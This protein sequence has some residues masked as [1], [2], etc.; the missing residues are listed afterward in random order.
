MKATIPVAESGGAGGAPRWIVS[1][2]D[3][4]T[5][6]L[7]FFVLLQA[8]AEVRDPELFDAGQGSFSRAIAGLGLKRAP[9]GH[10]SLMRE[11]YRQ[12]KYPT[13]RDGKDRGRERVIDAT[14]EHIRQLFQSLRQAL[15]LKAA[16]LAEDL[17]TIFATPVMFAPSRSDLDEA[18]RRYLRSFASDLRRPLD[19]E[20]SKLYVIGLAADEEEGKRRWLVSARRAASVQRFLSQALAGGEGG[21]EW[22]VYSW[23]A[24]DGGRWCETFGLD[25]KHTHVAI[26]VMGA[27]N[28]VIRR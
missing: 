26:A 5:L 2:C 21:A 18:D 1:F 10:M 25:A 17:V 7:A 20:T 28:V 15:A 14:D 24:A 16:E 22:D 11:K 23:G 4:I 8:F 13:R 6:L 27:K 3:M 12:L 9:A 19:R